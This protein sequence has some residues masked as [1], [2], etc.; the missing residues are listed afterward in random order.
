LVLVSRKIVLLVH[1]LD[2]DLTLAPLARSR[3]LNTS[4]L[5]VIATR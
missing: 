5:L 1:G 4:K 2:L 3:Q